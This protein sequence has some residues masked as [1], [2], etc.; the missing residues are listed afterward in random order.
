M[1][2]S[3]ATSTSSTILASSAEP[4]VPLCSSIFPLFDT[5][6]SKIAIGPM[7]TPL[8]EEAQLELV[9]KVKALDDMGQELV[10]A[11]IRYYQLHVTQANMMDAPFGMKKMKNSGEYRIE[12]KNLP[13]DLQH[14]LL[15]FVN[16]HVNSL[17]PASR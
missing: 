16:I 14:L 12:I 7:A 15:E 1:T 4:V 11:L 13:V 10:Y 9:A 8:V 2:T 6:R 3:T 17:P 5:L